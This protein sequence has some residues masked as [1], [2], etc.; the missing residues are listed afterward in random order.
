MERMM[1]R[2]DNPLRRILNYASR[3][4]LGH[5]PIVY[6]LT[7]IGREPSG[8]LVI[9]GLFAGDDEACFERAAAL[10]LRVNF[11]LLPRPLERVVA[12]MDPE[13]FRTTWL[14]NKAIYRTRMALADGARL[15]VLAPGVRRFGEDA[16]NDRIIRQVGYRPRPADGPAAARAGPPRAPGRAEPPGA[17]VPRGPLRG[18]LLPRARPGPRRDRRSRLHI[19]GLR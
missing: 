1:G 14:A 17:R 9:R 12:Y 3:E 10:S 7:V 16:E 2:A 13:E 19:W 15:V 8:E 6:I 5:L 18:G 4:F 11:E